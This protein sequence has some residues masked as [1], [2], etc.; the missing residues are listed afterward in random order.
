MTETIE[1]LEKLFT[2]LKAKYLAGDKSL[3]LK[4]RA[5]AIKL[6]KLR[7]S[8]PQPSQSMAQIHG[9]FIS[10]VKKRKGCCG[11]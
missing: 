7:L 6:D 3:E 4:L 5:V 11:R 8:A 2:A 10:R 1:Y 9:A